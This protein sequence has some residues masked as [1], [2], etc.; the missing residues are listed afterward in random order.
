M[1]STYKK[2]RRRIRDLVALFLCV[3]VIALG[4]GIYR[5]YQQKNAE[6]FKESQSHV[7]IIAEH[8]SRTFGEADRVL[9]IAI[10]NVLTPEKLR[11]INEKE[12]YTVFMSVQKGIPRLSV[13]ISLTP[14]VFCQHHHW[15]I[16]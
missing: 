9:D 3:A 5:D 10:N 6:L 8:A 7:R 16:P 14:L 15:I 11:H 13:C 1:T 4:Y 2:L 12:L